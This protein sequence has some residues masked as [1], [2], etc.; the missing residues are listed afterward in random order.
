MARA[1]EM[2]LY[3]RP[4]PVMSL[5]TLL[6]LGLL[7]WLG[8]WQWRRFEEKMTRRFARA[9]IVELAI[10]PDLN[11]AVYVFAV[12]D[13]RPGW[14]VFAPAELAGQGM[15]F[16][17][18]AFW[19]GLEPPRNAFCFL[20][21]GVRGVWAAPKP[22]AGFRAPDA[23]D[24]RRFY[25]I[26]LDDMAKSV[27]LDRVKQRYFAADYGPEPNP[28]ARGADPLPPERHLGYALTWWGMAVGLI[29]MYCAF[30]VSRGRLRLVLRGER[31]AHGPN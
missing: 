26:Q 6:A 31:Q 10:M 8:A 9:D 16:V 11:R 29:G 24:Q 1:H 19:P 4:L 27:G 5:C 2:R 17:D 20:R 15:A 30:H 3:V 12:R 22:P 28:F 7:I 14:R 25:T 21:D 13:G 18:I 23:P